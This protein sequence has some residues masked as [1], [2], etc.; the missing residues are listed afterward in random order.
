[1]I[2]T[3]TQPDEHYAYSADQRLE[4]QQNRARG[5]DGSQRIE[6]TVRAGDSFW[7]IA[8]KHGV[9]VAALTNWNG[10]AP[11]DRLMPGQKLVIWTRNQALANAQRPAF[12][13]SS[14]TR[15]VNY[16]VRQDDSFACIDT[17]YNVLVSSVLVWHPVSGNS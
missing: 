8:R 6:Y 10:M 16:R 3:A 9:T 4:R 14:T 17:L 12:N 7:R 11:K 15:R 1:M 13:S 5:A 2:P